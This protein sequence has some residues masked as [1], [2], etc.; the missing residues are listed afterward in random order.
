MRALTEYHHDTKD[1]WNSVLLVLP[2]F[3]LYQVGLLATHGI[4]NGVDLVTDGLFRLAGGSV[5]GYV[6]L[7]TLLAG[8]VLA[9]ALAVSRK[10]RRPFSRRLYGYVVL[11]SLVYA[12]LMGSVILAILARVPGMRPTLSVA[13]EQADLVTRVVMSVG[14]GVHEELVFRLLLFGGLSALLVRW[15]GWSPGRAVGV[16]LVVSSLL[17][18]AVHY[19]GP[20]SDDFTLFSF[21]YR[22]LA[23]ALFAGLY[24]ARSFAVAVYTHAIYDVLVLV[25]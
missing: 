16:S 8:A 20:L 9:V 6:V 4:R 12:G 11:E 1:L 23:G 14:A 5:L 19:V 13:V 24:A 10:G 15:P 21:S 25:F 7:N 18:S 22:F 2:L 17:F 3:L